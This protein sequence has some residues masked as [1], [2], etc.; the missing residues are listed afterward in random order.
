[1][2]QGRVS[3]QKWSVKNTYNLKKTTLALTKFNEGLI[4][5]QSYHF[6]TNRLAY[7]N[8]VA[9]QEL[10]E[11]QAIISSLGGF[12]GLSPRNTKYYFDP[13]NLTF[14]PIYYDGNVNILKNNP[15]NSY[16]NDPDHE[17]T[18]HAKLGA[19]SA[20]K[21][22]KKIDLKNLLNDLNQNGVDLNFKQ[23]SSIMELIIERLENIS[24]IDRKEKEF[25]SINAYFSYHNDGNEDKRI[26]FFDDDINQIKV[27]KFEIDTC[28]NEHLSIEEIAKLF[29]GEL[30]KN[31]NFYIFVSNNYNN[32][33]NGL[34]F[35]NSKV[36]NNQFE[37]ILL[38]ETQILYSKGMNLKQDSKLKKIDFIQK[39][40][41][42]IVLFKGG[43]IRNWE[44][45]FS[46]K[47]IN[48]FKEIENM[49]SG[50]INFFRVKLIN[51]KININNAG[52]NDAVN[53]INS[54]GTINKLSVNSA[55]TDGI[56][57]DFSHFK[58]DKIFVSDVSNDCVDM[59]F[60]NYVVNKLELI[61]CG[62]KAISVGESSIFEGND[63]KIKGSLI[64]LATKDSSISKINNIEIFD[65]SLCVAAY[66][67]KQEF[68]GADININKFKCDKNKIYYQDGSKIKITNEL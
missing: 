37:K 53:F 2:V 26:V 55:K 11:Y 4:D 63:I 46:G 56:D 54:S 13:I 34:F 42:E 29:S 25:K 21:K 20:I 39:N 61:N 51:V 35:D 52:C 19:N 24:K 58:I 22:I 44:I 49:F 1:M 3:N 36:L 6:N 41:S 66:R 67:K 48:N 18:Y 64:G 59:S 38:E 5:D 28:K 31:D 30:K 45:T 47:K 9:Q 27:C 57:F 12:H 14:R 16:Y 68:Y 65:S 32:Y 40:D 7:K 23:I 62:D 10:N 33:L 43:S 17:L 60:G 50:C 8:T 15:N